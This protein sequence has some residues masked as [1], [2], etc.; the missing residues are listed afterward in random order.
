MNRELLV[1]SFFDFTGNEI[2]YPLLNKAKYVWEL[3]PQIPHFIENKLEPQIL[4][5]VEEGAWLEPGGV[6]LAPGALVERGAVVRGPTII[7]EGTIVRTGAY[8]RGH[9]MTGKNCRIGSGVETRH[10]I[11]LNNSN[12][13]HQNLVFCSILGNDV[14]LAGG[15]YCANVR[16]DE[17]E[18]FI[19][20][21]E[22]GTLVRYSTGQ[23]RFGVVIGDHC[24]TGAMTVLQ[25]GT[26]VG[27]HCVTYPLIT[28]HGYIKPGSL[29][30]AST[31]G[32]KADTVSIQ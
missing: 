19:S 2:F 7:G 1:Q 11:L 18:I 21:I 22:E 17:K 5:Q 13:A 6:Y 20:V 23:T 26:L 12:L 25:P 10:A 32:A 24:R 9:F 8:I 15:S 16:L 4:G 27:K 31:H 28:V 3:I 14:N 30:K 29:L